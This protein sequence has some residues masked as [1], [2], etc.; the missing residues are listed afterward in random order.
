MGKM[1]QPSSILI[2]LV[3]YWYRLD[4]HNARKTNWA[5]CIPDNLVVSTVAQENVHKLCLASSVK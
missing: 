4:K 5:N 2:K 3:I 1:T